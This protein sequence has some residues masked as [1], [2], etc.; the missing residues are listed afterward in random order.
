MSSGDKRLKPLLLL[1]IAVGLS[2]CFDDQSRQHQ[3][4]RTDALKK[5]HPLE[6][7]SSAWSQAAEEVE[8][9]MTANGYEVIVSADRACLAGS[10]TRL[11]REECYA[12]RSG[13]SRWMYNLEGWFRWRS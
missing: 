5:Y 12:P 2:G 8:M 6:A 9:C 13:L 11:L 7:D 1:I 10:V 4:C 3:Q